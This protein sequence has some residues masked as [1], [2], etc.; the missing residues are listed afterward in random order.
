VDSELSVADLVSDAVSGNQD[1]WD[2]L[3]ERYSPLLMSVLRRYRMSSDDLYDV[4]QTV[5]LRMVEN[6]GKLREPRA[7]PGWIVTTARNESLRVLKAGARSRPFSSLYEGE[8][9]MPSD[10]S[11]VDDDLLLEERRVALLE[12][13]AELADR[14]RE[15]LTLLVA[16]PPLPYAEIGSRLDMK[17]GS[18]GPTRARILEK[19]RRYPSIAAFEVEHGLSTARR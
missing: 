10:D 9:P 6:L 15:L 11:E 7:L 16:D 18:I 14:E 19:L 1:A 12:A 2:A 17:V 13:F 3:V 8:A 4:A 5:W